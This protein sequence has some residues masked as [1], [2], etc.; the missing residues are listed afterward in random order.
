MYMWITDGV[1]MCQE[2]KQMVH[3]AQL[4]VSLMLYTTF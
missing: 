2:K 1:K 4:S 3:E